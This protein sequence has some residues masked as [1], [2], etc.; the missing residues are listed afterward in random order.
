MRN[1]CSL[2][3]L[4]GLILFFLV[5]G[6]SPGQSEWTRVDNGYF[7][8]SIPASLKKTPK[9]GI[10]SFVQEYASNEIQIVFDYGIYSNNFGDWPEETK[11]EFLKIDNKNARIGAVKQEFVE[12]FPYSTQVYIK[13]EK[14]VA[15]NMLA[16]CKSETE[17]LTARKIFETI[18]FRTK[19]P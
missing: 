15:L 18:R 14:S 16:V 13:H 10:D 9:R 5:S 19:K 12:G 6:T 2:K 17:M 1:I 7:S 3:L 8:F 11:F 4:S